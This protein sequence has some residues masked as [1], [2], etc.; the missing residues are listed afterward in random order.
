MLAATFVSLLMAGCASTNGRMASNS[1]TLGDIKSSPVNQAQSRPDTHPELRAALW[2]FSGNNV[3][4]RV[5]ETSVYV[6]ITELSTTDTTSLLRFNPEVLSHS[7][8]TLAGGAIINEAA[9]AQS[10]AEA[11]EAYRQQLEWRV[12]N[13]R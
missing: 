11:N 6:P 10:P 2:Q 13:N 8:A 1:V 5:V 12:L 9:A 3:S 4:P 7:E